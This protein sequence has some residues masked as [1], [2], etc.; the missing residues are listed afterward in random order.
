MITSNTNSNNNNNNNNNNNTNMQNQPPSK[1]LL[2]INELFQAIKSYLHF[3]QI[4]SWINQTKGQ[5]PKNIAFSLTYSTNNSINLEEDYSINR[6]NKNDFDFQTFPTLSLLFQNNKFYFNNSNNNTTNSTNTNNSNLTSNLFKINLYSRKRSLNASSSMP[7]PVICSKIHKS[8]LTID[9]NSTPVPINKQILFNRSNGIISPPLQTDTKSSSLLNDSNNNLVN[10][11]V[12][13]QELLLTP[14]SLLNTIYP[15]YSMGTPP[16]TP[17]GCSIYSLSNFLNSFD[18]SSQASSSS[19]KYDPININ[20]SQSPKVLVSEHKLLIE[21]VPMLTGEDKIIDSLS[22]SQHQNNAVVKNE[23][24]KLITSPT[25]NVRI[26]LF[27]KSIQESNKEE[28]DDEEDGDPS[29]SSRS[30]RRYHHHHHR[31]HRSS[32]Y[33]NI[34]NANDNNYNNGGVSYFALSSSPAPLRKN[35]SSMFDFDHTLKNPRSIKK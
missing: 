6:I 29:I 23:T 18:S 32:K 10:E 14:T 22:E 9:N 13:K 2:N 21:T 35:G 12:K 19:T 7:P 27:K 17:N 20:I 30:S 28:L 34:S 1:S 15:P 4:S 8:T 24:C 3:S 25:D 26:S 33:G 16:T 31:Q 11:F 5:Q